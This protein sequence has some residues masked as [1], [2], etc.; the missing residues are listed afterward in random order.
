MEDKENKLIL[1][2][3]QNI[4]VKIKNYFYKLFH[5]ENK[6]ISIEKQ[7]KEE[8]IVDK[9]NFKENIKTEVDFSE[10]NN[11]IKKEEFLKKIEKDETILKKLSLDRLKL[12]EKFYEDRVNKKKAILAELKKNN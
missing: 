8:N 2:E 5:K 12:L 9:S 10:I 11:E 1:L 6:N 7:E 4:F 3:K